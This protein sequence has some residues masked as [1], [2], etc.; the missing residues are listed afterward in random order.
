MITINKGHTMD[1]KYKANSFIF[2][3]Y[4]P[5]DGAFYKWRKKYDNKPLVFTMVEHKLSV[6]IWKDIK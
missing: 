3:R 4:Q 2:P 6:D 1:K 5:V